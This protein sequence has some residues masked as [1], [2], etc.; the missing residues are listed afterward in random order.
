MHS[1]SAQPMHFYS[2]VDTALLQAA[3]ADPDHAHAAVPYAEVGDRFG[4]S[5]THVRQLLMAAERQG[6]VKLQA[7]GGHRVEIQPRLWASYDRAIAGGMFV[8]DLVYGA[9]TGRT[10]AQIVAVA[11]QS[12][13]GSPSAGTHAYLSPNG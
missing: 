7:R 8:R 9:A 11:C 4:V 3:S 1:Y 13:E 5:R 6:L 12:P 10:A 2:G